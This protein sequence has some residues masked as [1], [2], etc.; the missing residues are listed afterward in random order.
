[1]YYY[2]Q[3]RR[4]RKEVGEGTGLGLCHLIYTYMYG[5]VVDFI[6]HCAGV[7]GLVSREEEE[8]VDSEF[9]VES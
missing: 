8:G 2:Y 1:M 3:G 5:V 4:G 6:V 7:V 9:S